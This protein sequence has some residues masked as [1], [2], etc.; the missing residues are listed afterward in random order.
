MSDTE[1]IILTVVSFV[2]IIGLILLMLMI[3]I[4]TEV[5]SSGIR[6]KASPFHSSFR[7]FR[8][9]EISKVYIKRYNPFSEFGVRGSRVKFG[10]RT[11]VY[12]LFGMQRLHIELK[13]GKR[14]LI[15]TQKEKELARALRKVEENISNKQSKI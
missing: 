10:A 7:L 5:N 11:Q 15:G 14:V 13:N 2:V 6:L 8:W 1:L 9:E 12:G 3:R 4:D